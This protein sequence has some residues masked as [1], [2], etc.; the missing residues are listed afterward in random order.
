MDQGTV[1]LIAAAIAAFASVLTLALRATSK[2]KAE[3]R[4]IN[5]QALEPFVVELGESIHNL[6]AC[7]FMIFRYQGDSRQQPKWRARAEAAREVLLSVRP[8]VRYQLWGLDTGLRVLIRLPDWIVRK[9]ADMDKTTAVL[10]AAGEL[11][12]ALDLSIQKCYR[13][14][15]P[16]NAIE[17]K[18][19][20]RKVT[21]LG[22]H[23][24]DL[25]VDAKRRKYG[26]KLTDDLNEN[27]SADK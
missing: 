7:S 1:T 15:R 6:V 20:E 18:R 17:R 26:E 22:K 25:K 5:R 19:V 14:G 23:W 24:D 3:L 11:C 9:H 8:K 12:E 13:F 4:E 27:V 10:D 16:P 2:R 21:A